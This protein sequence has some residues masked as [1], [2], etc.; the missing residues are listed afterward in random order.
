MRKNNS[1]IIILLLS[2]SLH[3]LSCTS[4]QNGNESRISKDEQKQE[5]QQKINEIRTDLVNRY[6]PIIFPPKDFSNRKIFTY[7]LQKLLI[8]DKG[9]YVLF[10]GNLDDIT[11]E[12][13]SFVIHFNSC[14]SDDFLDDRKIKYH[15]KTNYEDIKFL[16][17]DPPKHD[18]MTN[19]LIS[20]GLQKDFFIVCSID[21]VKKVVNYSVQGSSSEG[22]EDVELEIQ[23]PD[24]FSVIGKLVEIVHYPQE[25]E[26]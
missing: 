7:T 11:R 13:D 16:I 23:F 5:V 21:N 22:S 24:T 20:W 6:N 14:I 10:E 4:S 19:F 26:K 25:N 17:E 15:L 12:Q 3:F 9:R 1:Y 8:N 2:V 18:Y